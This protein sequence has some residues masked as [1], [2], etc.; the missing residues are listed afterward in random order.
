MDVWVGTVHFII[1][2]SLFIPTD[3]SYSCVAMLCESSTRAG[4]KTNTSSAGSASPDLWRSLLPVSDFQI[5]VSQWDFCERQCVPVP[6]CDQSCS[7][8]TI[9]SEFRLCIGV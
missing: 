9:L 2:I 4:T 5:L 1:N 7:K 6:L 3:Y 8:Q